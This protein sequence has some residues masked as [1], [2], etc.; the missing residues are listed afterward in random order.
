MKA[1][2]WYLTMLSG[3]LMLMPP[4][5]RHVDV[6]HQGKLQAQQHELVLP[7]TCEDA[8]VAGGQ[9]GQHSIQHG[10]GGAGKKGGLHAKCNHARVRVCVYQLLCTYQLAKN[11]TN[12]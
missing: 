10:L 7:H 9:V 2:S 6:A 12:A 3:H 4:G 11:L 1:Q 8:C 5:E